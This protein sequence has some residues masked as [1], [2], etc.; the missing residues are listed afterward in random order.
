MIYNYH[1]YVILNVNIS[2]MF[3]V[4]SSRVPDL[5]GIFSCY[6]YVPLVLVKWPM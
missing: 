1:H 4:H 5:S 2:R 6:M 3:A